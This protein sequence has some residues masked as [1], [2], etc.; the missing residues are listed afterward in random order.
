MNRILTAGLSALVVMLAALP[1]GGAGAQLPTVLGFHS[2]VFDEGGNPIG[3]GEW[4]A[5]FRIID[6]DGRALYEEQQAVTAAGGAVSALVGNGLTGDGAPTGGVTAEVLDPQGVRYLEVEFEGMEPLPAMELASV[7]YASYAQTAL[8]V[9]D[10]ALPFEAFADGVMD[11][12][13]SELTGGADS[14]E[15]VLRSEIENTTAAAN[16]GVSTAELSVSTGDDLQG[17]LVD[18]DATILQNASGVSTLT[19][20]LVAETQSRQSADNGLSNAIASEAN[21]RSAEDA[22]LDGRVAA[23]ED[24]ARLSFMHSAW[25]TVTGGSNPSMIGANASV[26]SIGSNTYRVSLSPSMSSASYAVTITPSD[27]T[28]TGIPGTAGTLRVFNKTVSSFDVQFVGLSSESF[29]FIAMG[30]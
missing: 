16:I 2:S 20:G 1:A 3:D 28:K 5:H 29:D 23:L 30:L 8:T 25:G 24:T 4:N 14:S 11:R 17:V 27:N 10:G 12:I 21:V 15:I 6:A 19:G 26:S 7:P 13:A 18:F 22:A 9:A